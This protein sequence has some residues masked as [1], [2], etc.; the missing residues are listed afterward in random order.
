M[1]PCLHNR[2]NVMIHKILSKKPNEH[3]G[4]TIIFLGLERIFDEFLINLISSARICAILPYFD[5]KLVSN[6]L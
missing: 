3:K 6:S 5:C 4:G 1:F 2:I